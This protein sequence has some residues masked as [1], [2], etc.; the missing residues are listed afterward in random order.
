[1]LR[2]ICIFTICSIGLLVTATPARAQLDLPGAG[3][4]SFSVI[5][6]GSSIT[7]DVAES[8]LGANWA[9]TSHNTERHDCNTLPEAEQEAC[10]KA[11][12]L[13]SKWFVQVNAGV[14][15]Q[16]GKRTIFTKGDL[17]PGFDAG[18]VVGHDFEHDNGATSPYGGFVFSTRDVKTLRPLDGVTGGQELVSE[19]EKIAGLLLGLNQYI[20]EGFVIGGSFKGAWNRSTPGEQKPQQVCEVKSAGTT[21]NGSV[22]RA[23]DCAERFA[24]PLLD[25][26]NHQFRFDVLRT[27]GRPDKE[28]FGIVGG[29]STEKRT[30]SNRTWNA[31]IGPILHPKGRPYQTLLAML[32]T[33]TDFTDANNRGKKFS[34]KFGIA[35]RLG[36][37]LTGF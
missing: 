17:T 19:T 32:L 23:E 24:G 28:S 15:A 27:F 30:D 33:F 34:D 6:G 20:S 36:I 21:A 37:P 14:S 10:M 35:L 2:A 31:A 4:G 22:V 8:K 26:F 12:S 5:T 29:I 1:M 9:T 11:N 25:D 7:F 13:R 3:S 16:K 18:F